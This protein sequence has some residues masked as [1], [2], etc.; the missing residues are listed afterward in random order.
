MSFEWDH[1]TR[2]TNLAKHGIDFL[3]ARNLFDR[4]P[5]VTVRSSFPE[6]ERFLT[7]G[8]IDGRFV[9]LIW[10]RLNG[11]IRIISAWGLEMQKSK[12]IVRCAAD[13][14]D[15][16]LRRGEDQT[17]WAR[18]DAMSE[19]EREAAIDHDDEGTFDWSTT[20]VGIPGP[21][22]Q[23]IVRFDRD[24]IEWFKAQGAGYQMRMNAVLKSFVDAQKQKET[25][26]TSRR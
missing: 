6:E 16:M 1:A 4:R 21:K 26:T 17:D 14:L 8:V 12:V 15:E 25:S 18:V 20:Q 13:E 5:V 10:T 23:L 3:L 22:Q 2:Q 24:V 19:E 7:T 9:T 11:A